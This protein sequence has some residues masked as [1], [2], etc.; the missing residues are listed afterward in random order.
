MKNIILIILFFCYCFYSFS[1]AQITR[2]QIMQNAS[3]Y[4]NLQWTM[5]ANNVQNACYNPIYVETYFNVGQQTTGMA[6]CWGGGHTIQQFQ[7]GI[8]GNGKAGNKC[9]TMPNYQQNTYG[10]DCSG[11]ITLVWERLEGHL[12]TGQLSTISNVI[13]RCDLKPGDILNNA[14]SH[15]MLFHSFIDDNNVYVIEA[16][17]GYWKVRQSS[18][19]LNT[20]IAQGYVPRRYINI[21]ELYTI[22][23]Y[24]NNNVG[25]GIDGVTVTFSNN[26][27]TTSTNSLGF[28]SL[29]VNSGWSGTVT[30]TKQNYTFAPVSLSFNNLNSDFTNQNFVGTINTNADFSASPTTILT[31][32]LVSFTDQ[33]T[34]SPMS[35]NW[36]FPGG[37]P[38]SSSSQQPPIITYNTQGNYNVSLT[39][40]NGVQSTSETKYNYITVN[41]Q[42]PSTNF[43][44][45]P[46]S[47]VMEFATVQFTDQ[48]TNQPSS[49]EWNFGDGSYSSSPNPSHQY[50]IY[51]QA[52]QTFN[53]TLTTSNT[54][55]SSSQSKQIVVIKP[56]ISISG[57]VQNS[58]FQNLSGLTI[59]ATG[60]GSAT[61]STNFYGKYNL[62][63]PYD[64]SG[65][66][67]AEGGQQ[68]ASVTAYFYNQRFNT[69]QDFT[70]FP[71]TLSIS[72]GNPT[73]T[74]YQ[75]VANGAPIGTQEYHWAILKSGV[76]IYSE[77]FHGNGLPY[78]FECETGATINYSVQLY[79]VTDIGE[80]FY[81]NPKP[82]TIFPCT[83]ITPSIRNISDCS[84]LQTG[85]TAIFEDRSSPFSSLSSLHVWWEGSSTEIWDMSYPS[86]PFHFAYTANCRLFKH[87]F[88]SSGH[89][90]VCA[91]TFNQNGTSTGSSCMGFDIV[92]C[93]STTNTSSFPSSYYHNWGGI[94]HYWSGKY[95]LTGFPSS[96]YNNMNMDIG[97][98][99]Q[100]ILEPGAVYEP[101]QGHS[102]V[103][104]IDPCLQ[105]APSNICSVFVN[106]KEV[107]NNE[108]NNNEENFLSENEEVSVV[109]IPNPNKGK[110]KIFI[111]NPEI[112][113]D[114]IEIYNSLGELISNIKNCSQSII[115]INVLNNS[116]GV[117]F[118]KIFFIDKVSVLKIIIQ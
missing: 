8:A 115:D 111:K 42:T 2:P 26:C 50:N 78:F 25:N 6:Y 107:D 23:G 64:W 47:P 87:Y 95:D 71:V 63:L 51:S 96:S 106:K 49:W 60:N 112:I 94:N 1:Q 40:S 18:Y 19:N 43:S 91:E 99:S 114:K 109:A 29:V 104:Y 85:S 70:L 28:Y 101:T 76:N 82:I 110:F 35:W 37:V 12:G 65:T 21:L 116:P 15:V 3:N 108:N 66:I 39:I 53:I 89:Y 103:F 97:A 10:V 41:P 68:Y 17:G 72:S 58:N 20:L 75:F 86:S 32:G 77:W 69:I 92:N 16:V 31:G 118:A 24:I 30:P 102:I 88:P 9:T 81:A 27:G 67:T 117:Y 61:T 93:S 46:T 22:S 13:D 84:T 83:N 33:S 105:D 62:D 98:C 59:T 79:V 73:G 11:F 57:T 44:F 54:S 34:G 14:G 113:P 52:S 5:G 36:S 100:I 4:A 56:G 55:G 80:I 38:S 48:S 7:N 74:Y 45:S 90:S